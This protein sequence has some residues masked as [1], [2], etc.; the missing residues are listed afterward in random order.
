[1]AKDREDKNIFRRE[2]KPS[3]VLLAVLLLIIFGAA[4]GILCLALGTGN[5]GSEVFFSYFRNDWLLL[6]NLVP[7]AL[8]HVMVYMLAG[9]PW[10]AFLVSSGGLL[11]FSF[12][13]RL[14]ILAVSDV[15]WFSDI[16]SGEAF[17]YVR[18]SA[19][20]KLDLLSIGC[21]V[22]LIAV[23]TLLLIL[24]LKRKSPWFA[25]RIIFL[26]L[27]AGASVWGFKEVTNTDKYGELTRNDE[28]IDTAY[29]YQKYIS[30]GFLYPLI[31]SAG[32]DNAEAA[33]GGYSAKKAAEM[34]AGCEASD[35]ADDKAVSIIAI[36]LES[37]ADFSDVDMDAVDTASAY[38]DYERVK[39]ASL[40][41]PLVTG[42]ESWNGL[43]SQRS[44]LTGF[45]SPGVIRTYTNSYVHYLMSQGFGT[46]GI[47]YTDPKLGNRERISE[48]LGFGS[49]VYADASDN[50]DGVGVAGNTDW[51]LY[52]K[53]CDMWKEGLASGSKQFIFAASTQNS[54]PYDPDESH[55][56]G[57]ADD[58][59][60]AAQRNVLNNY[61]GGVKESFF[62]LSNMLDRMEADEAPVV[63]LI[64]SS[65]EPEGVDYLTAGVD[66]KIVYTRY[67]IWANSAAKAVIG[68][69]LSGNGRMLST[70]FLLPELFRLCGYGGPS[71]MKAAQD[72]SADVPVMLEGGQY[73]LPDT[74]EPVAELPLEL[75]SRVYNFQH[76]EYYEKTSFRYSR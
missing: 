28:C 35:I 3:F 32:Q 57:F 2:R 39:A 41:G 63:V 58:S 5:L 68:T 20:V 74:A 71:Y 17:D 25:G 16:I 50:A 33:P 64:Y 24:F 22:Y 29:D 56:G 55:Y 19:S 43:V 48:Y 40:C 52:S 38:A 61:L 70:A 21:V 60:P 73:M 13:E 10:L 12:L 1:M 42:G 66:V 34:L 44:F 11:F 9:R 18:D 65:G 45:T 8:L 75:Q 69:D 54:A 49:F 62:Y 37:F 72:I 26:A 4:T 76:M 15:I 30:K 36:Q 67:L 6:F 27:L 23:T 14:K 59:V 47:E 7:A 31:L 51:A 46:Q 53:V